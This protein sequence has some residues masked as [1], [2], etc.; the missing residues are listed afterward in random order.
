MENLDK[1][2]ILT[3]KERWEALKIGA[4]PPPL[5][6][7]AGW[8]LIYH[9]VDKKRIYRAGAVLLDEKDPAR[10]IARLPYPILEPEKEYEKSGDVDMVVFPEGIAVFDDELQIYYGAA[11]KVIGMAATRLSAL[12][13]ELWRYKL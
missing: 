8:L 5:R 12:I 2:S 11:D 13:E 3:R 1:H 10:I 7:A 6:T 4:G 9:G